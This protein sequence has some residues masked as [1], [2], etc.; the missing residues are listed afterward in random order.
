MGIHAQTLI[1]YNAGLSEQVLLDDLTVVGSLDGGGDLGHVDL[2]DVPGPATCA[3]GLW[4][5]V[6]IL[7]RCRGQRRKA[8]RASRAGR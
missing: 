6:G 8:R 1:G 4:G 2:I 7:A 5:L 3:L